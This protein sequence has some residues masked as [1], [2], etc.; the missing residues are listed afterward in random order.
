MTAGGDSEQLSWHMI[1]D[2]DA[3][4]TAGFVDSD[5]SCE[6]VAVGMIAV[7]AAVADVGMDA[8]AANVAGAKD[9]AARRPT[10]KT[11]SSR[12]A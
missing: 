10:L 8:G 2:G 12:V 5:G 6:T 3:A 1:V 7:L 4:D 9:V 11:M